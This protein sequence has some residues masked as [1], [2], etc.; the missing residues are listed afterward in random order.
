MVP[1][2][3]Y[4]TIFTSDFQNKQ[5]FVWICYDASKN[6]HKFS[7]GNYSSRV[8][9]TFVAPVNFQSRQVEID[10]DGYVKKIGLIDKF[11]DIDS[12]E[13]HKIILEEKRNGAYL[14]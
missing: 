13:F 7:L 5:N 8:Q 9:Q 6:L 3:D 12:L 1:A 14:E 2:Q 11:I 10:Y 4:E